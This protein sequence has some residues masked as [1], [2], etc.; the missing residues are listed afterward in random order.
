MRQC[1]A[2]LVAA[3]IAVPTAGAPL[4]GRVQGVVTV[5]GRPLHGI[6]VTLVDLESGAMHR[7]TSGR[8]GDFELHVGAGRYVITTENRDGLIVGRGPS[9]VA[10]A[11]G[12]TTMASLDLLGLPAP[13]P[14]ETSG[15]VAIDHTPVG[16]LVAGQY[17]AI[18][19]GFTPAESV[20]R[21][22]VYF[23]SALGSGFYFVEMAAGED[24]RFVGKLPR[25]KVEASPI[26]YYVEA[27][28]ARGVVKT[29]QYTATVVE[30]EAQCP[31]G[32]TV[33]PVGPPG[34]VQV[35][36]AATGAAITPAGFAASGIAVT[37]GALAAPAR[38]RGCRGHQRDGERLQSPAD[39]LADAHSQPDADSDPDATADA[40]A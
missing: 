25:P 24:G 9:E 20:T 21:S 38:Q 27:A 36:S 12:A 22:R 37:V 23:K 8:E 3:L 14:D 4:L 31:A 30:S 11:A 1:L 17:A 26:I 16:C 32:S 34:A 13:L 2:V 18:D 28:S 33:A 39:A 5:E 7:A 29:P 10:V 6:E 35:Y 15:E 19:A 40:R